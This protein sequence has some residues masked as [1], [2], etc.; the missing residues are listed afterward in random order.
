PL[1]RQGGTGVR[2]SRI[3]RAARTVRRGGADRVARV[4]RGR[5]ARGRRRG[6]GRPGSP[7]PAHLRARGGERG[8]GRAGP[9]PVRGRG[10]GGGSEAGAGRVAERRDRGVD[11]APCPLGRGT[12]IVEPWLVPVVAGLFGLL[13]GSFLNVCSLR[14]PVDESVVSPPSHCPGC[15]EPIRWYDSV[16]VVSWLVLRG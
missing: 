11:P 12:L 4:A 13:L 16:P 10:N 15:D 5:A 2:G 6:A 3:P 7:V 8:A 14:W 1:E 9:D